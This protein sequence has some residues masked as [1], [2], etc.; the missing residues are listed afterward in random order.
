MYAERCEEKDEAKS[1]GMSSS[2]QAVPN[3]G[4]TAPRAQ[5]QMK[6]SLTLTMLIL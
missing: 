1:E 2:C 5:S 3:Q 4:N 6:I